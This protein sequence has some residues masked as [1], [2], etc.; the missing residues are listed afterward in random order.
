MNSSTISFLDKIR[1]KYGASQFKDIFYELGQRRKQ[2]AVQL[3]NDKRVFFSSLFILLPEIKALN[4]YEKLNSRNANAINICAKVLKD[5]ELVTNIQNLSSIN[6]EFNYPVLKWM[7]KTGIIDDGLNN[8]FDEVLDGTV[9]LL[10]KT[11]EDK[12]ILPSV[13]TMIFERN[14]K[15][16]LIHD[17]VWALFQAKDP[18]TLKLIAKYLLSSEKKDT[19]LAWKL[20]NI[21]TTS[22]IR[23]NTNS[24]K[25]YESYIS[26]FKE[27]YSYLYFTGESYQLTSNPMPYKV[28]LGSK[29]LCKSINLNN[30]TPLSPLTQKEKIFLESFN[31]L[32]IDQQ[33]L[34]SQTSH[35]MYKTNINRWRKWIEG[36]V[37]QQIKIAS[38]GLRRN[39]L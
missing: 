16:Y 2:Q 17:L 25:Q 35:K 8:E 32:D 30:R 31:Q 20:L 4:L 29:Y 10:I 22:D 5:K 9:S 7:F 14:K 18:H 37:V 36:P 33:N 11:Y 34:L 27:N 24:K 3:I 19:E 38:A 13:V 23:K 12:T 28:D 6:D 39:E 26:W 1:V 21:E 15:G